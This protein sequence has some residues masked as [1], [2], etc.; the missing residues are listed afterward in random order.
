MTEGLRFETS[1]GVATI[2]LDRPATR[3]AL[4]M[5]DLAGFRAALDEAAAR[6]GLRALVVT[7]AG[8]RAFSA[9][10]D[11]GDVGGGAEAWAENPLTALCDALQ[12]FPRPTVARIN[13]A[14]IGGAA[15]LSLS[16]DFRVGTE[17]AKLFVPAARIGIHYEPSGLARAAAVIGLQGAR[18]VYLLA[19]RLDAAALDRLGYFDRLA[20]E[21][22][23]DEALAEIL[24][25]I[26]A[27]A[28]LAVDGMKGTFVEALRGPVD[29][30]AAA[31]RVAATWRSEDMAEGL[32]ALRE[33]RAPVFKGR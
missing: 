17:A 10:V 27:G 14:V 26:R 19:E 33:K 31:A 24:S 22:G 7:G 8:D 5:A 20:P 9:G 21:G 6:P 13:G 28:P 30:A 18:R 12:S 15:E 23:L 32:A 16:C 1:G 4:T 3:N 11:L 25:A 29:E 2:T